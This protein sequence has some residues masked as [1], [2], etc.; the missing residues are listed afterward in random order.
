MEDVKKENIFYLESEKLTIEDYKKM[1]EKF[2][3]SKPVRKDGKT[4]LL[5]DWKKEYSNLKKVGAF[6]EI[7]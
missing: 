6:I 1:F 7:K 2:G 4:P 5:S 3:F